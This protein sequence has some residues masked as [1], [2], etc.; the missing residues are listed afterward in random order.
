M[1]MS[2]HLDVIRDVLGAPWADMQLAAA[3]VLHDGSHMGSW[4]SVMRT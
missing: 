1:Q 3:E 4:N 2:E